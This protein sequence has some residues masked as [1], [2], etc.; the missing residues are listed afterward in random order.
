MNNEV[1]HQPVLLA[2]VIE[3][4]AICPDGKYVDATFGRGGHSREILSRLGEQGQ[5]LALD[6]DGEAI[7]FGQSTFKDE[8]FTMVQ[9]DFA[10]ITSV[11]ETQKLNGHVDGVLF[12]LGVS[13]PQLDTPERGFSFIHDGPLDMRMDERC[14]VTAASYIATVSEADLRQV[15]YDYGEERYGRR[16]ANAI[17]TAREEKPITRTLE[18]AEIIASATPKRDPGKHPATRSFQAIRIAVNQELDALKTGLRQAFNGLRVG[19]RLAVITFHSLEDRIVKQ[20]F[21]EL[22]S[23]TSIPS[24]LPIRHASLHIPLKIIGRGIK[25]SASE[26]ADN[27]RARSAKLRVAEK[28]L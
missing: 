11:L 13:S 18:L 23:Q 20:F 25:A 5:L 6:R 4:L 14:N 15:L 7:A 1:L 3:N 2:E 28:L 21:R 26:I 12:D 19:G 10:D 27:V 17:V 22:A 9:S 24:D 16:I 8:R